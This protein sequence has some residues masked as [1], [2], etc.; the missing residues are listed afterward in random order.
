MGWIGCLVREFELGKFGELCWD[1]QGIE[2]LLEIFVV[3]RCVS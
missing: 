1:G 3:S 2:Q